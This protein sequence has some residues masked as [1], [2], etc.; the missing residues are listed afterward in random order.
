MDHQATEGLIT[1]AGLYIRYGI[2]VLPFLLLEVT[3]MSAQTKVVPTQS[4]NAKQKSQTD[5][6]PITVTGIN[7]VD[8]SGRTR[9][10]LSTANG[11]PAIHL[12][13]Q[14]GTDRLSISLD[15][16]GYASIKLKNPNAGGATATLEIDDKGTHVKFDRPGGASSYLFL[17]NV[18]ESGVVFLD[19]NGERKLDLLV[20][21]AGTTEIHRYD[22][23]PS[24]VP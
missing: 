2:F 7:I 16:G 12:L 10:T 21:S 15:A 20:T 9:M 3:S 1:R 5:G 19:A 4:A 13:N 6:K 18:G 22:R 17:N 8:G 14:D 24:S 23:Q 11:V